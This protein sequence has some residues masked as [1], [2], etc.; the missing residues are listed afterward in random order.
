MLKENCSDAFEEIG[1]NRFQIIIDN[2]DIATFKKI[3]E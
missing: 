1:G 2:I 3:N